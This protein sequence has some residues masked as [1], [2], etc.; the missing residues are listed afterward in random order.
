MRKHASSATRC[1]QGQY[2]VCN[3]AML[4]VR[5]RQKRTPEVLSICLVRPA[6]GQSIELRVGADLSGEWARYRL[7]NGINVLLS[8]P[9]LHLRPIF[10]KDTSSKAVGTNGREW[11]VLPSRP[12]GIISTNTYRQIIW[13][14]DTILNNHTIVLA[15]RK[16]RKLDEPKHS[17]EDLKYIETN[18]VNA[19]CRATGLR[20]FYNM[21]STCFMSV[22]L[23]SLI[24]NPL[25]R[26]FYL[27]DGHRAK[28]CVQT[29][30]MSCAVEE[31]FAEF[32]TSDKVDGY[33]PVNLLMTS[34]KCEQVRHTSLN[35]RYFSLTSKPSS[36][37]Y[38]L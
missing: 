17:P 38:R 23:Q 25:I 33:G 21:G 20:G 2:C 15:A 8:L 16:K 28:E 12:M 29:N 14:W 31:V 35:S 24:H 10:R 34:W 27:T 18:T 7:K 4:H 36:V 19:P 5:R 9:G 3:A 22:V 11:C 13:H 6:P 1:L 30:C 37:K 32:F 26:N